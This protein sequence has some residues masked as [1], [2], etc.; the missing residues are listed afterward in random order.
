MCAFEFRELKSEN[1]NNP[2]THFSVALKGTTAQMGTNLPTQETF[3]NMKWMRKSLPTTGFA[4]NAHLITADP[5]FTSAKEDA[6]EFKPFLRF[7]S[8]PIFP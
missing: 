3:I 8:E 1:Q 5:I 4:E 7:S 2:W 6:D